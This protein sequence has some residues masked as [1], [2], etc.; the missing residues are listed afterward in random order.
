MHWLQLPDER[1]RQKFLVWAE[2]NPDKE[3]DNS[4]TIMAL[5]FN[6]EEGCAQ[7][8]RQITHVQNLLLEEQAEQAEAELEGRIH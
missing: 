8:H 5:S 3:V 4:D 1:G 2:T 6:E 7:L